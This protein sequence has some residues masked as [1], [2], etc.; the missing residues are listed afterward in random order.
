MRI[1]PPKYLSSGD[2]ARVCD[3]GEPLRE[4]GFVV[5]IRH[6]QPMTYSDKLVGVESF[7]NALRSGVIRHPCIRIVAAFIED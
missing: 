3:A 2:S 4:R 1:I 5:V 7:E 6:G